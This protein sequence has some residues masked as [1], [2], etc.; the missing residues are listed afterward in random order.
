MKG[1]F[2][3]DITAEMFR[4]GC[5]ES[6][7]E[8]IAR[9]EMFDIE[10]SPWTP[11]VERPPTDEERKEYGVEVGVIYD[12]LLPEDNQDVLVTTPYGVRQTT[13][14]TDYGC[15]F[16]DYEDEGEVIAWQPSPEP[17]VPDID[18]GKNTESEG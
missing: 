17:Y 18:V 8:L 15:Y 3:P 16:E 1:L 7:E 5:L 6:I 14:Y 12:C 10:Y 9:G 2:I 13:F 4:N 11:I